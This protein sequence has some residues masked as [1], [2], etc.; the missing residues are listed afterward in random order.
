MPTFANMSEEPFSRIQ[1]CSQLPNL[2]H[3]AVDH[4][5]AARLVVVKNLPDLRARHAEVGKLGPSSE[6]THPV[7][8]KGAPP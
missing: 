7:E 5:N 1:D 4:R 6:V 3:P 2:P 8:G